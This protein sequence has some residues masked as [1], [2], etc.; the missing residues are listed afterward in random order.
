VT[1]AGSRLKTAHEGGFVAQ[2]LVD[3]CGFLL[4][5]DHQFLRYRPV[6]VVGYG[7]I[8]RA[9]AHALA[10]VDAEVLV[11]EPNHTGDVEFPVTT[12]VEALRRGVFLVFG[13]TG[14]PSMTPAH[15]GA[16]LRGRDHGRDTLYL[17]SAS[18]KQLEFSQLVAF[19]EQARTD[20]GRLRAVAGR[21]GR[22]GCE[23]DPG[24]GLRYQ[25]ELEDGTVKTCV[26]LAH[27]YPVLFFPPHT[28]GAPNRAMDP[29][30]S[31]LLLAAC[32]LLHG[33]TL[34]ERRVYTVEDLCVLP[35][36]P[37]AWR[38]LTDEAG[39]LRRWCDHNGLD[40]DRYLRQIGFLP[41]AGRHGAA[42]APA[43]LGERA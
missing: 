21:E 41:A 39:L 22:V 12:L 10:S 9:L 3:E 5:R 34:L 26:L 19:L 25:V 8:G 28:H 6:V 32:G 16:F 30:M 31:Q 29:V 20:P 40:P 23:L 13:A 15:L 14:I 11:V 35:G 7:R 37:E 2:A 1:I 4:R 42:A 18:S 43:R 36:L 33:H 38:V 27:G 24:V 17:A